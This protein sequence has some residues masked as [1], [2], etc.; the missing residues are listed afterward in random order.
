MWTLSAFLA[1]PDV[2]SLA[3]CS[4]AVI[5]VQLDNTMDRGTNELWQRGE[6]ESRPNYS[7]PAKPTTRTALLETDAC[8]TTTGTRKET[9]VL[10][11][12]EGL[13]SEEE[14]REGGGGERTRK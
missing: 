9:I 8:H 12:V 4:V 13:R 3:G 10:A 6:K 11:E 1:R 7:R 14:E 2:A 5:V